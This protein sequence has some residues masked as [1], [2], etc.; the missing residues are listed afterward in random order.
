MEIIDDE[1]Q[2]GSQRPGEPDAELDG[3]KIRQFTALRR[4]AIRMRSWLLIA[5]TICAVGALQ[6]IILAV[7]LT[8]GNHS[9]GLWQTL[10]ALVAGLAVLGARHFFR[11]AR[12]CKR[13]IE[14]P[15]LKDPETPPDFSTLGDGSERWKKLE[16][17][18]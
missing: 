13:E 9:W 8:H 18:R 12:E 1:P 14:K 6:L 15:I 11:K 2:D 3:L 16:D 7:Q 10:Y 4:S 17:I 5:A